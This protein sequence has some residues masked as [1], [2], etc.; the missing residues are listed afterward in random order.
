VRSDDWEGFPKPGTRVRV[1]YLSSTTEG[2][3][4]SLYRLFGRPVAKVRTRVPISF[5]PYRTRAVN[6][7]FGR[8]DMEIVSD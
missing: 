6:V 5:H 1:P 8:D 7:A 2:E 4:I 3:V